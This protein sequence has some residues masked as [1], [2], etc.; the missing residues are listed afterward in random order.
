MNV[1]VTM[2]LGRYLYIFGGSGNFVAFK[3]ISLQL[4]FCVLILL[5]RLFS[6]SSWRVSAVAYEFIK[7]L[8]FYT[9]WGSNRAATVDIN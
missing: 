8:L 9:N 7:F 6:L 2:L 5:L 4:Y 3:Y 1:N